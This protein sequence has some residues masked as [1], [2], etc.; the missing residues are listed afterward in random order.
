MKQTALILV[1][2]Q[3][4]Y[5]AGGSHP[6]E[7]SDERIGNAARLLEVCRRKGVPVIHIRHVARH[8]G[9]TFFL[10]DTPGTEFH[11]LVAPEMGETII[12]KHVVSSYF[13]TGLGKILK[14]AG[15]RTLLVGGMQSDVCAAALVRESVKK[16]FSVILAADTLA[17]RTG[18]IHA[19]TLSELSTVARRTL[20]ATEIADLIQQNGSPELFR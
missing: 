20:T 14:H 1:D 2:L 8:P 16:G 4:D 13:R 5:F 12:T 3:R 9:R 19:K 6:L 18:E 10:P 7:K 17:A 11:P 15:Y